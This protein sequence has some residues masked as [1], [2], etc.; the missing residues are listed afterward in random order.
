MV[1]DV[2]RVG[3]RGGVDGAAGG[4]RA[5]YQLKEMHAAPLREEGAAAAAETTLPP[6][7]RWGRKE[8]AGMT[9]ASSVFPYPPL[10]HCLFVALFSN[11]SFILHLRDRKQSVRFDAGAVKQH[12]C[13]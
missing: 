4:V 2:V 1:Q 9:F 8:T 12:S 6:L 5:G 3:G 7:P 13:S 11:V 10:S